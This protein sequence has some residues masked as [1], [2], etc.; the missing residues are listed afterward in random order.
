MLRLGFIRI[1]RHV[2]GREKI[3]GATGCPNAILAVKKAIGNGMPETRAL[4]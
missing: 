4:F 3:H 1:D 2:E